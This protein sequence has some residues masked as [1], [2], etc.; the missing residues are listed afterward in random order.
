MLKKKYSKL[1]VSVQKKKAKR[2]VLN[3]SKDNKRKE[4]IVSIR[5]INGLEKPLEQV[6]YFVPKN[7][8]FF[9][10]LMDGEKTIAYLRAKLY[11]N[12][13]EINASID[14]KQVSKE[15]EKQGLATQMIAETL[16]VLKKAGVSTVSADVL[17]G[18]KIYRKFGFEEK[19]SF[20]D[21]WV[22]KKLN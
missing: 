6:S 5:K 9:V 8:H 20:G 17:R 1:N 7:N 13:K 18:I 2:K 3:F 11:K 10:E 12:G 22:W 21:T 4:K 15:F 16:D 14:W 19:H